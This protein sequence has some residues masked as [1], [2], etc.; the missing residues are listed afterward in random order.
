MARPSPTPVPFAKYSGAGNDFVIVGADS[1]GDLDPAVLASRMCSRRTG[2]GVDGMALVRAAGEGRLEVRF[3]NPDGSEFG[4]CGNGTRCV[5]LWAADRDLAPGG[6]LR[7]ETSDGPI[8]AAVDGR[9]VALDYRI[10]AYLVRTLEVELGGRTRTARLVQIGT[11]HLIVP[12]DVLPAGPIEEAC[13]PLRHDPALGPEGANVDLV[14][15][16]EPDLG[17]IRTFERGVEGE[18][19]ACGSGAMAAALALHAAGAAG[20]ELRLVTRSGD[21]LTVTLLDPDEEGPIRRI[22]LSGPARRIFE[23]RYPAP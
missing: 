17:A 1:V 6:S 19:L 13:R 5:A 3:F 18:T 16:E 12:L 11:P 2:V 10:E 15:L 22:R 23:G 14:A 21:P 7:I 9:S 8:D 20:P 4:T